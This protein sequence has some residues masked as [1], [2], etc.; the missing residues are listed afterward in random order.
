MKYRIILPAGYEASTRRY[1]VL[2]LLHGLAG[3]YLNWDTRTHL[4]EYTAPLQLILVMPDAGNSWYTNS[5]SKPE[6]RFEDYIAKDLIAEMDARYRTISTRHARA[7]AGLSMGGY[8]AVKIALRYPGQFVFAGSFSGVLSVAHDPDYVP[9]LGEKFAQQL[10]EIFG[11][12]GGPAYVANDVFA[13]VE[14]AGSDLPYFWIACGTGDRLLEG[15]R[16]FVALLHRRKVAYTYK[17]APGGHSWAFWDEQLPAMFRDLSRH[18]EL[19]PARP[20]LPPIM[21]A[22]QNPSPRQP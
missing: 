10:P 14:K 21:P 13:L 16:E 5:V 20:V 4:A 22:R 1:P 8:G 11:P 17:E 6:N 12:A 2:Y 7:I 19:G 9:R 18:M 15:N 3:D